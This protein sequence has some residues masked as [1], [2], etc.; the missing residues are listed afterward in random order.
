MYA[1]NE[2]L[3]STCCAQH[4]AL[5][6][7]AQPYCTTECSKLGERA[8]SPNLFPTIFLPKIWSFSLPLLFEKSISITRDNNRKSNK[9]A[10]LISRHAPNNW[11]HLSVITGFPTPCSLPNRPTR[12]HT[13]FPLIFNTF[14]GYSRNVTRTVTVAQ[15]GL[16]GTVIFQFVW[17]GPIKAS[18]PMGLPQWE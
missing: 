6:Y 3:F 10:E 12:V 5:C 17:M 18:Q 9:L 7:P 1:S 2:T 15:L 8:R 11:L 16:T 14:N 4:I 13:V